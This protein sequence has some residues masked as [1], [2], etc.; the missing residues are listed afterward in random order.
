MSIKKVVIIGP[1]STGKSLLTKWLAEAYGTVAV[2][3]YAR[4]Y[5]LTHGTDYSFETLK[6]IAAGQLNNEEDGERQMAGKPDGSPM[7]I[8]TDMYVMKVWSEY[9]FGRCDNQVLKTIA[10]RP[11]D[12]Y[13]L[14]KP[15]IPWVKDELREYPDAATREIL[16]RHYKDIVVQQQVPW[17]IVRGD[18]AERLIMA[19]NAV[20]DLLSN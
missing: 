2:E 4:I 19:K 17:A 18:Y 5:L 7:F 10:S 15:D 16:Y 13:L 1:E 3:E 14:C 8:D 12:L 9:V 20:D 11:Y 6:V